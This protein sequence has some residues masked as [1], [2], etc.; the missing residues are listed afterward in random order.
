MKYVFAG[1]KQ[2]VKCKKVIKKH[3][4]GASRNAY[5]LV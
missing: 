5:P 1:Q 3:N 2:N 4:L